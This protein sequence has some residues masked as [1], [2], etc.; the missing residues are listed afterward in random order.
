MTKFTKSVKLRALPNKTTVYEAANDLLSPT[1]YVWEGPSD[2][3]PNGRYLNLRKV[4][5]VRF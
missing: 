5:F 3:A 4:H 2:E 1:V